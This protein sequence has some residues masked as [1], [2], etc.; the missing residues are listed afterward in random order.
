MNM[1]LHELRALRKSGIIWLCVMAALAAMYLSLYS[2]IAQDAAG[3]KSLLAGYPPQVRAMLGVSL[4]SVTSPLGFYSMIITF[5]VLCGAI[6]AMHLGVSIL[7]KE[8]R[9][10]TADFLLVK[11]VSRA[12]IISAKITAALTLFLVTDVLYFAAASAMT[13]MAVQT[14]FSF[15]VFVLLNLTL[16]FLQLIFFFLGLAI[17]V[18]FQKLKAVLPV[19]LGVVFGLYFIGVLVTSDRNDA[20]R[21]LSP[22][23]YFNNQYIVANAGYESRYL[24]AGAVIAVICAAVSYIVYGRKDIHAVN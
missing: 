18:F 8:A 22:F 20:S 1:V 3:F 14:D 7:S 23:Q 2:S 19:S 10:R 12:S 13:A 16:L 5:V 4:D 15:K 17:S 9:G 6:E 24:I 21:F 11:P